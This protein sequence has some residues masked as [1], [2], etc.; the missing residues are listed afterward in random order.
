MKAEKS[1]GSTTDSPVLKRD[2]NAQVKL[3]KRLILSLVS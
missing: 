2:R 3:I 1:A